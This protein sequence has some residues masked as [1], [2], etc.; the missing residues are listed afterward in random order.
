MTTAFSSLTN[1]P[2]VAIP[3]FAA[4]NDTHDLFLDPY[5]ELLWMAL[6]VCGD[7]VH[8]ERAVVEIGK[9]S[10]NGNRVLRDWFFQSA[11]HATARVAAE[12]VRSAI[13]KSALTYSTLSYSD[14][15]IDP[16][17]DVQLDVLYSVPV[18]RVI[19]ELDP[20]AR[21]VLVLRG[22]M[23]VSISDCAR[24]LE[25]S[26]DHVIAAYCRMLGWLRFQERGN[27]QFGSDASW[28][29][30]VCSAEQDYEIQLSTQ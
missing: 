29:S 7:P 22:I 14:E 25:V 6:L 23:E 11:A 27:E 16:L 3:D 4:A 19:H 24:L 21:G 10:D 2:E 1:N 28:N 18:E 30:E 15:Y 13:F 12:E 8:A 9:A 20:F 5:D 26:R 17:T